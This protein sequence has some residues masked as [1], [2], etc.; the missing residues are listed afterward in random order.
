MG[1]FY[2]GKFKPKNPQKYVGDISKITYRS[3]WELSVMKYLDEHPSIIKYNSEGMIIPYVSP[4][5]KKVHRYYVDFMIEYKTKDG[6]IRKALIEVK[7]YAQTNPPAK[8]KRQTK[9]YVEDVLT[10]HINTSKWKS[11]MEFC[12]KNDMDFIV[13]TEKGPINY[14]WPHEVGKELLLECPSINLSQK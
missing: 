5:D 3:S 8:P 11:A 14:K 9:R 7:P 6:D 13:L 1:N 2:K 10:F 12:R 4:V